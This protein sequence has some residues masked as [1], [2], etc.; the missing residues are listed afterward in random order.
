MAY[1]VWIQARTFCPDRAVVLLGGFIFLRVLNPALVS[2]ESINQLLPD[3]VKPPISFKQNCIA[4]CRL[5]QNLSNNK[6]YND[7]S[8]DLLNEWLQQNHDPLESYLLG[9]IT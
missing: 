4:L 9:K 3:D 1:F 8:L 7:K 6:N 5:L 2:P